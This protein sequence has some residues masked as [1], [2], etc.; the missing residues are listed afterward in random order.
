[1]ANVVVHDWQGKESG[2]ASLD[3]KVA[4]ESSAADLLHRA[5]VRQ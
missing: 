5:V 1:M 3:L 4:K 2:K